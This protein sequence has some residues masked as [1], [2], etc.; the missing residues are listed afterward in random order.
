MT[1]LLPVPIEQPLATLPPLMMQPTIS[2][3]AVIRAHESSRVLIGE[4]LQ[5]GRDYGL[6][7]GTQKKT[8]WKPGAER[9]CDAFALRSRFSIVEREIDHDRVIEWKKRKKRNNTW[10]EESG[11]SIGL[12]R[13]V[14]KCELIHRATG[15][16]VGEAIGV[17][18]TLESR[19]VDRPRELENTVLKMA[20]KRA[21]V[22]A[23]LLVLGLSEMF[24]TLD[25]DPD[26]G[27]ESSGGGT[28][29]SGGQ[30]KQKARPAS[31]R[32]MTILSEKLADD[33]ITADERRGW[34]DRIE[35]GLSFDK[36]SEA[37]ERVEAKLV[38]RE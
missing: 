28:R 1:E 25:D 8:L 5:E 19:Y 13:Y 38:E 14:V 33:R 20:E 15:I 26:P 3:A 11:T 31:Q 18:S 10:V 12:Y 34:L 16:V 6:I 7:P 30:R 35:K 37:I 9:I 17:A 21:H 27:G 22:G 23:V 29:G 36:A 2:P 32:Q 24:A 4:V